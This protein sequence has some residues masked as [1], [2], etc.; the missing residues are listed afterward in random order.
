MP[1]GSDPLPG[2]SWGLSAQAGPTD[3]DAEEAPEEGRLSPEC[4]RCSLMKEEDLKTEC[5]FEFGCEMP[6]I[7]ETCFSMKEGPEKGKCFEKAE[8]KGITCTP[9]TPDPMCDTCYYEEDR[10]AQKHC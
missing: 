9:N 7:C 5:I 4:K 2:T 10:E 1:R 6:K 3:F 8:K